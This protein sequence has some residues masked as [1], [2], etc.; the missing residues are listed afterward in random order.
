MGATGKSKTVYGVETTKYMPPEVITSQINDKIRNEK[1]Q[2]IEIC[3]ELYAKVRYEMPGATE[4]KI[5]AIVY[6]RLQDIKH[7]KKEELDQECTF[8]PDT[9]A[10]TKSKPPAPVK[11]KTVM[12]NSRTVALAQ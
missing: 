8:K 10:S 6:R 12:R 9:T 7:G 4:S 1:Q 3:K 2:E 11:T 5:D